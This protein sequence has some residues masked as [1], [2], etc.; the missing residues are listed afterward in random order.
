M[1]NLPRA[2]NPW[3]FSFLKQWVKKSAKITIK[4][5]ILHNKNEGYR[6]K[7]KKILGNKSAPK[8]FASMAT[9][10]GL[11]LW[12]DHLEGTIKFVCIIYLRIYLKP[13]KFSF[14]LLLLVATVIYNFLQIFISNPLITLVKALNLSNIYTNCTNQYIYFSSQI[15]R[16]LFW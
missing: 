14:N 12:I 8:A 16:L 3:F 2:G 9:K 15:S 4:L 5:Q 13:T 1:N 10:G 11:R 7:K 6:K